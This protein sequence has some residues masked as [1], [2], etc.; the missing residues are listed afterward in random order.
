MWPMPIVSLSQLSNSPD[1]DA[2]GFK[3]TN[4]WTWRRK[5][6]VHPSLQLGGYSGASAV[7]DGLVSRFN[8]CE[9]KL[10]ARVASNKAIVRKFAIDRFLPI[11]WRKSATRG[12]D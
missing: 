6:R 4:D 8:T 10:T 9:R 2:C 11:L 3:L 1:L 5:D 7:R 12:G